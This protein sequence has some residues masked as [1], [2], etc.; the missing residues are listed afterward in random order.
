MEVVRVARV[1]LL[2]AVLARV[3]EG[4]GKMPRLNMRLEVTLGV[5]RLHTEAAAKQARSQR[6]YVDV[7]SV[8]VG[9]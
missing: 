7:K 4:A 6:F 1:E 9:A 8:Q 2:R 3:H 5:A